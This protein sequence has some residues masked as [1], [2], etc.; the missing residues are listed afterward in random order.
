MN[1]TLKG[2]SAFA[3]LSAASIFADN[4]CNY[5]CTNTTVKSFIRRS[6]SRAKYRQWAGNF[7]GDKIDKFEAE[8]WY[9]IVSL[10]PG[11]AATFR[12]EKIANC[13]FGD[14]CC[15]DDCCGDRVIKVQGSGVEN[16]D[17]KAWLA[18]YFYLPT[19]YNGC[20]KV[21]PRIKTFFMD[22]DWYLGMD[23]WL[24]GA[25][26]RM[27][28][29][30]VH[31]RWD[32]NFCD[33]GHTAG[34]DF[35]D[36]TCGYFSQ[37]AYEQSKLLQSFKDYACGAIP[38]ASDDTTND[39]TWNGLKY[40]RIT[41]CARKE[42]GFADLRFE[43]GWN[44]LNCEDYH[45]GLNIQG[46]AP[47]GRPSEPCYLF[48][49]MIGNGG[50]G[51]L[52]AG[53]HA[54]YNL[55]MS[56]DGDRTFGFLFDVNVTTLFKKR[57]C[58]T[59]DLACKPNSAYML[60]SKFETNPVYSEDIATPV[61]AATTDFQVGHAPRADATQWVAENPIALATPVVGPSKRFAKV[62]APV[63]NLSTVSVDVRSA[64]QV[65]LVAM[66]NYTCNN[67]SWD[68]GYDFWALSCQKYD[69]VDSCNKN[70]LCDCS[71]KDTW[72][73][74]GD[75]RMFGFTKVG[76]D[77]AAATLKAV[78]LSA[79]ECNATIY[80]GTNKVSATNVG[81]AKDYNASV[82]SPEYAWARTPVGNDGGIPTAVCGPL[83]MS[84]TATFTDGAGATDYC[85]LDDDDVQV[86][87]SKTPK[88]LSCADLSMA[89]T[90]G[91]SHS[92]FTHL[93]WTFDRE[94][95]VPYLGIGAQ[96]EFGKGCGTCDSCDPCCN[97]CCGG[98][99]CCPTSCT[100]NSC[101]STS[102][103]PSDCCTPCGP[104]L[105]CCTS[106][107]RVWVKGGMTYGG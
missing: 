49:P 105:D 65:D 35:I 52:G 26:F 9:G 103:C 66:F 28:G 106:E 73:L 91:L 20:F 27:Y 76:D 60:A 11:Y 39:I 41:S 64:A 34:T 7:S 81:G 32:L 86:Q 33:Q 107:W 18:D 8:S 21:D 10:T 92:L 2:L 14:C 37:A 87:T 58:R 55:W 62:Y 1:K 67:F 97:P 44:F 93:S 53:L 13:L 98:T 16:R 74:K 36:H 85:G 30:V 47:T 57:V 17:T 90:R 100:T 63:A 22:I 95:W 96:V 80:A 70:N 82:D 51:E 19:N 12:S 46:A 68:I 31:T 29:T 102:C 61:A 48:D 38:A 54:H 94:D 89:R 77:A 72:T 43:L 42:T 71:L 104:C 69:C 4:C 79:T 101:T 99:T 78:P 5:D 83:A 25:Y 84:C 24:S 56:E 40:A 50:H 23:E 88:F 59:F 45:L 15:C 6:D 3:L 75:A